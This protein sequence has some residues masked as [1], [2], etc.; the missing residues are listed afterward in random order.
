MKVY[1]TDGVT[2]EQVENRWKDHK[3]WTWVQWEMLWQQNQDPVDFCVALT[4]M[5]E[6]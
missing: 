6:S 4:L 1:F 2:K 5:M 3:E